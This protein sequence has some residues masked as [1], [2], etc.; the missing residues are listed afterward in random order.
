MSY[1]ANEPAAPPDRE[2]AKPVR[3]PAPPMRKTGQ[4]IKRRT[5]RAR[6]LR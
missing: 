1:I 5:K 6:K 2:F 4:A 3:P